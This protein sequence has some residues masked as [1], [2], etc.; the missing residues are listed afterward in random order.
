MD[1]H[2]HQL[3]SSPSHTPMHL[4]HKYFLLHTS[5]LMAVLLMFVVIPSPS[6]CL[7]AALFSSLSYQLST[8]FLPTTASPLTI[9]IPRQYDS[10]PVHNHHQCATLPISYP[11]VSFGA[12]ESLLNNRD[13][14][15]YVGVD[16]QTCAYR[17]FHQQNGAPQCQEEKLSLTGTTCNRD[18]RMHMGRGAAFQHLERLRLWRTQGVIQL[19]QENNFFLEALSHL[20][21]HIFRA[22]D[23]SLQ[24]KTI[25]HSQKLNYFRTNLMMNLHTSMLALHEWIKT[26][27]MNEHNG[28]LRVTRQSLW[29]DASLAQVHGASLDAFF[30]QIITPAEPPTTPTGADLH[31][32]ILPTWHDTISCAEYTATA[33]SLVSNLNQ[34]VEDVNDLIPHQNVLQQIKLAQAVLANAAITFQALVFHASLFEKAQWKRSVRNCTVD[35]CSILHVDVDTTLVSNGNH[36]YDSLQQFNINQ[37]PQ[38]VQSVL[39][40][41]LN[42]KSLLQLSEMHPTPNLAHDWTHCILK[43]TLEAKNYSLFNIQFDKSAASAGSWEHFTTTLNWESNGKSFSFVSLMNSLSAN[44][45]DSRFLQVSVP[46]GDNLKKVTSAITIIPSAKFFLDNIFSSQSSTRSRRVMKLSRTMEGTVFDVEHFREKASPSIVEHQ[47][48]HPSRPTDNHHRKSHIRSASGPQDCIPG[49]YWSGLNENCIPCPP[50]F[51]SDDGYK[52]ECTNA[53]HLGSHIQYVGIGTSTSDCNFVCMNDREY[54]KGHNCEKVP[55]GKYA[56]DGSTQLGD[57]FQPG[58]QFEFLTSGV[59]GDPYS[60]TYVP[61]SL[62]T[63]ASPSVQHFDPHTNYTIT[64]QMR[65]DSSLLAKT[66][67]VEDKD[68]VSVG[69]AMSAFDFPAHEF[70]LV[71]LFTRLNNSAILRGRMTLRFPELNYQGFDDDAQFIV[72]DEWHHYAMVHNAHMN[73]V[74]FYRDGIHISAQWAYS[75]HNSSNV[76]ERANILHIGGIVSTTEA[77]HVPN[78]RL[79]PAEFADV[80]IKAAALPL[81]LLLEDNY[82]F[83]NFSCPDGTL[84]S[85]YRCFSCP[86]SMMQYSGDDTCS[87]AFNQ[88]TTSDSNCE[89][90]PLRTLGTTSHYSGKRSCMCMLGDYW[91][92]ETNQCETSKSSYSMPAVSWTFRNAEFVHVL[93]PNEL[94]QFSQMTMEAPK[95]VVQQHS[96]STRLQCTIFRDGTNL[97]MQKQIPISE[98]P[99]NLIFSTKGEYSIHCSFIEDNR[100]EGV[101]YSQ[102]VNIK[103]RMPF[104]V[105]YNRTEIVHKTPVVLMLATDIPKTLGTILY[106]SSHPTQ[107]GLNDSISWKVYEPRIA[108]VLT[109]TQTVHFFLKSK[110]NGILDGPVSNLTWTLAIPEPQEGS[111][112]DGSV[113]ETTAQNDGLQQHTSTSLVDSS[114]QFCGANAFACF[115]LGG[116][117][118]VLSL[119]CGGICAFCCFF[120]MYHRRRM[121][122]K[123]Y[124]DPD[125]RSITRKKQQ[126]KRSHRTKTKI[127]RKEKLRRPYAGRKRSLKE[128]STQKHKERALVKPSA[129]RSKSLRTEKKSSTKRSRVRS[130]PKRGRELPPIPPVQNCTPPLPPKTPSV[131]SFR[132]DEFSEERFSDSDQ[133]ELRPPVVGTPWIAEQERSVFN[134]LDSNFAEPLKDVPEAPSSPPNHDSRHQDHFASAPPPQPNWSNAHDGIDASEDLLTFDIAGLDDLSSGDESPTDSY[135]HKQK[136]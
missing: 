42:D 39:S 3:N 115:L 131:E 9:N 11:F 47:T 75:P 6:N 10:S 25:E 101:S 44:E 117:F 85:E 26:Q 111:E 24:N 7:N 79:M 116:V 64:F 49:T 35:E 13:I 71:F 91:S 22:W 59:Q 72:D 65:L 100:D 18:L 56:V 90:C 102:I 112:Q 96:T 38:C 70:G 66:L 19:V 61:R 89:W 8:S 4:T 83:P 23:H 135:F 105:H 132:G 99:L 109:S 84:W 41:V 50:G 30:E 86:S 120:A 80:D 123:K 34:L 37:L 76:E 69:V 126:R 82:H 124:E 63:M 133:D 67:D 27:W 32:L 14:S 17:K 95:D 29:N 106:R 62:L 21:K 33:D 122:S 36:I 78:F 73:T 113:D 125:Y 55:V 52:H 58:D 77:S 128:Q 68:P 119:S 48:F 93:E 45:L 43:S 118:I 94:P 28:M 2:H 57:C 46:I 53:Y 54:K 87:C 129:S 51:W 12:L 5:F 121:L 104:V 108:P 103:P 107:S 74:A 31:D 110:V 114:L 60:C 20:D 136:R 40:S 92:D 88:Y 127:A 134:H 97:E 130:P 16:S 98:L 81:P 15:I 1:G